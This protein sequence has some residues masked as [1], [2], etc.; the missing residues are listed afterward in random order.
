MSEKASVLFVKRAF[1]LIKSD[2]D[3]VYLR[4]IL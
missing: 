2:L 1:A 4:L 3:Q